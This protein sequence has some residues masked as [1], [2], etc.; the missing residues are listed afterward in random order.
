MIFRRQITDGTQPDPEFKSDPEFRRR[1]FNEPNRS[2][3]TSP[4]S[5]K[6]GEFKN[7]T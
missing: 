3:R 1:V 4:D 2:N 7:Y 6:L 5:N